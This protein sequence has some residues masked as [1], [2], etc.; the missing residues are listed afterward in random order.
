[1]AETRSLVFTA[2]GDSLTQGFVPYDPLR[3]MGPGISYT[4]YLDN[5]V[6]TELS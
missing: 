6:A 1:M 2:L 3:P 5:I 4:S